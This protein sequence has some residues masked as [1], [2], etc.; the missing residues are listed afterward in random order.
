MGK[1][2]YSELQL[3]DKLT[4]EAFT[5]DALQQEA[6][7]FMQRYQ[8]IKQQDSRLESEPQEPIKY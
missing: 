1:V 5:E 3:T 6:E 7:L 2:L 4:A 8:E